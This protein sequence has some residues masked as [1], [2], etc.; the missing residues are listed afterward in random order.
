M[1]HFTGSSGVVYTYDESAT[2][3]DPGG[4][5]DVYEGHSADDQPVAIKLVRLRSGADEDRI[6]RER[7]LDIADR[8]IRARDDG[9][10][11][12]NLLL[13]LDRAYKANDL[14]IVM[15]RA[16]E[17]LRALLQKAQPDRDEATEILRQVAAGLEQLEALNVVHRDLKPPNV[18]RLGERWLLADFGIARDT[19]QPTATY[20]FMGYGTAPYMAPEIWNAQPATNQSDLYALGVIAFELLGG[21]MP[22]SGPDWDDFRRQHLTEPPPDQSGLDPL[23]R[24]IVLRL[25]KKHPAERYGSAS[26]VL[27]ALGPRPPSQS[28]AQDTLAES[29]ARRERR[30]T[31]REA[32]RQRADAE[33][34]AV[35]ALRIRARADLQEILRETEEQ[36]NEVHMGVELTGDGL[37]PWRF[38]SQGN[39]LLVFLVFD[40]RSIP[41]GDD[42]V[43]AAGSV[44]LAENP[45]AANFVCELRPGGLRWFLYTFRASAFMPDYTLGP[46]DRPHGYLQPVF[47]QEHPWRPSGG[48]IWHKEVEMLTAERLLELLTA[49]IDK[50]DR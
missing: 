41:T 10:S 45:P 21:D 37:R 5:G 23:L 49:A 30:N 25:L 27:R 4:M 12:S 15:A 43:I 22:F 20:T 1:R 17:S 42:P 13:P 33:T 28:A 29:L 26:D 34:E 9:S 48:N 38:R 32:E 39:D 24:R 31:E 36:A 47:A 50:D 44:H 16:D 14:F 2:I 7:E 40:W 35:D 18:L 46:I 19:A 6:R 11:V 3:G 8:L